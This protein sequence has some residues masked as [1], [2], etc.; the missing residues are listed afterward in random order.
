MPA[1]KHPRPEILS[2]LAAK[3]PR[4]G[5]GPV[6]RRSAFHPWK[7]V[8][9]HSSCPVCKLNYE[10]ETGFYFGAMYFSYAILVGLIIVVAVIFNRLDIFDHA[11]WVIPTAVILFLP[12]I[13]RYS[14]LLMLYLIYPMMYKAKFNS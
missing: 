11:L 8:D 3:C 12:F 7:F 13:F 14:R 5:H 1:Y 4:C 6:F 10:P 9:M 2:F